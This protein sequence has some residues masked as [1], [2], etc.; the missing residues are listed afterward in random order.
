MIGIIFLALAVLL[1]I[2]VPVSL[3]IGVSCLI[4]L[5]VNGSIPLTIIPQRIYIGMDSF[6]LMAIPFFMMAGDLMNRGGVT[7]RLIDFC[8]VLVGRIKGG[9]AL[10]NI[11][12][13]MLFAGLNGAAVADVA[14]LGPLEIQMMTGS[15]YPRNYAA[16]VTAA[17]SIIGPIIPPSIVM[18]VYGVTANVSVGGLFAGAIIPGTLTGLMMMGLIYYQAHK[19]SFPYRKEPLPF[20]IIVK[21]IISAIPAL[22]I[23]L[24][25][26]GGM[27]SGVF[28]ATE[29]GAVAVLCSIIISVF[30]YKELKL[31][32]ILPIC[33]QV[34]INSG[35]VVLIIA[36]AN[37]FVWLLTTYQVPMMVQEF[38]TS[39]IKSPYVFLLFTNIFLLLVGCVIE[40][41][42]AI[43]LFVPVLVPLTVS[44]GIDPLHFGL[45]FVLNLIVGMVT[46]PVG[47]VLYVTCS[48]AKV[49]FEELSRALV[50]FLIILFAMLLIITYVPAFS[51]TLPKLLGY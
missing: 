49:K 1:I 6:T 37:V 26:V 11:L 2:G 3:A 33:K 50:P 39:F 51:L 21:R 42:A 35:I 18:V 28:T 45:I 4:Q 27:L 30:I 12:D 10:V 46:P 43:I 19:H 22:T 41:A 32:D 29:A 8:E 23:P 16:A 20:N 48:V 15:G 24:V 38:V 47:T 31:K 44:Y 34:L 25:I 14:A 9:M 40:S 17:S 5:L 13:S 36:M 7:K